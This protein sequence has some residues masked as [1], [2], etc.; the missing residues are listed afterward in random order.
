MVCADIIDHCESDNTDVYWIEP[1]R[2][3][4]L[5]GTEFNAP[6]SFAEGLMCV[7]TDSYV[8]VANCFP[9]SGPDGKLAQPL[10]D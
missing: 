4:A 2:L 10:S 6:T 8:S 3:P 5:L 1:Y 9:N 7:V